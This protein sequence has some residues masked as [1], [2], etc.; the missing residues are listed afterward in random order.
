MVKDF[1][2]DLSAVRVT[3]EGKFDAEFGSA[4]EGVGIM[5]KENVGH[6]PPDERFNARKSLL[7]LAARSAFT[8]VINADEIEMRA[9]ETDSSVFLA[10]QFHTSL[11]VEIA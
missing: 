7:A 11:C 9:P 10:Q 1:D 2:L 3:G 6:I 8:L 4:I 5:R